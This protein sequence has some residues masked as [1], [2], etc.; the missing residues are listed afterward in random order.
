MLPAYKPGSVVVARRK[1]FAVG[2]V[3]IVQIGHIEQLKRIA[4]IHPLE[5]A[6]ELRGDNPADSFDSR[7]YGLIAAEHIQAVVIWP[8]RMPQT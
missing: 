7:S 2:D 5:D 1:A 8:R 3:V 6:V 4:A